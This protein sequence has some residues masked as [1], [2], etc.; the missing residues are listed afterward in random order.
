MG[1]FSNPH[2]FLSFRG[3]S[4]FSDMLRPPTITALEIREPLNPEQQAEVGRNVLAFPELEHVVLWQGS[5][6]EDAETWRAQL[7]PHIQVIHRIS[8]PG[9]HPRPPKE[10]Q[11]ETVSGS[12]G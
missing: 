12:G 9:N 11:K 4:I 3:D 2:D 1:G 5:S 10:R 6:G 8:N 7:P